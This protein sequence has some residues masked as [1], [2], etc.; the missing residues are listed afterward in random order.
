VELGRH[1]KVRGTSI[2]TG[3]IGD[4]RQPSVLYISDG[5]SNFDIAKRLITVISEFQCDVNFRQ[6]LARVPLW[7]RKDPRDIY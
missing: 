2:H 1:K 6:G 5:I 4:I 3:K 7:G